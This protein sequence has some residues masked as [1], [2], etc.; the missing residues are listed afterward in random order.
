MRGKDEKVEVTILCCIV[1]FDRGYLLLF[2]MSCEAEREAQ[3][4]RKLS[5]FYFHFSWS[6]S[7]EK[8]LG[9]L[10]SVTRWLNEK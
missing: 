10:I 9:S 2:L 5:V 8:E 6:N 1:N 7:G 3:V 4:Y